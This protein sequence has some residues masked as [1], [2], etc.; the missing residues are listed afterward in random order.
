MGS[1]RISGADCTL[2]LVWL[3]R[4]SLGVGV[5][6]SAQS[7]SLILSSRYHFETRDNS[8]YPIISPISEERFN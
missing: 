5:C 3:A 6:G 8:L 4:W 2:K 7:R 1:R